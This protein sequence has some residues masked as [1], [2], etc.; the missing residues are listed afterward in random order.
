MNS[1]SWMIYLAEVSGSVGSTLGAIA[2][3]CM[4]GGIVATI[5]TAIKTDLDNIERRSGEGQSC[6]GN[7]WSA[8]KK[9][10]FAA[11]VAMLAAVP[12]PS[13]DTIYAI[14]ASEVGEEVVK[15]NIGQKT[16][17]A[18]EAWL[19]KQISDAPKGG[20]NG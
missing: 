11:G 14:A 20:S 8:G 1:L 7:G 16:A 13:K 10:F 5:A 19:D 9:F 12:I 3:F 18:I 15:S 2:V 6:I 4:I 17:K